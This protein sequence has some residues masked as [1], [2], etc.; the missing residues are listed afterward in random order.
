VSSLLCFHFLFL[1]CV[2]CLPL[3]QRIGCH[4]LVSCCRLLVISTPSTSQAI[5]AH[6]RKMVCLFVFILVVG[7]LTWSFCIKFV[8]ISCVIM[9]SGAFTTWSYSVCLPN[10]RLAS[11]SYIFC[12]LLLMGLECFSNISSLWRCL[13]PTCMPCAFKWFLSCHQGCFTYA[14]MTCNCLFW[15]GFG[16]GVYWL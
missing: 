6:T 2:F 7:F 13:C 14:S 16:R 8:W 3:W 9:E 4:H 15:G 12:K 1:F 11:M 10:K 5:R